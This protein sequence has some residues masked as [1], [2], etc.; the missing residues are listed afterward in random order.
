MQTKVDFKDV[1]NRLMV[2]WIVNFGCIAVFASSGWY[3]PDKLVPFVGFIMLIIV[4][5]YG[6]SNMAQRRHNCSLMNHYTIYALLT[7]ATAMLIIN[8]MHTRWYGGLHTN[9]P[10]NQ[11]GP[12]IS[13]LWVMS[14]AAV[15]FLIAIFRRTKPYYCVACKA[16]NDIS[17]RCAVQSN[18]FH[19]EMIFQ[20][21]MIFGLCLTV[22]IIGWIYY[23]YF[24]I[25][26]NINV[27][28]TF[29]YYVIPLVVYALSVVYLAAR[30]SGMRFEATI[31]PNVQ[32]RDACTT[33][34]FMIVRGDEI[35]L[36]EVAHD[37][38]SNMSM[39]DT[40]AARTLSMTEHLRMSEARSIFTELSGTDKFSLRE[41]FTTSTPNNNTLHYA[42]F[43]DDDDSGMPYLQGSWFNLYE[44]SGMMKSGLVARSFAYEMHR[45]YTMTLAWKTYDVNGKR[46][47][48]IKNYRPTFRLSDFKHWEVD[49]NDLQWLNV[50]KN[51]E[52]VPFSRLRKFWRTYITH[53][54][55][56][57]RRFR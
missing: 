17:V 31:T 23:H 27:P 54:D 9:V 19:N 53:S 8:L 16:Q 22:A 43:L 6:G 20:L 55:L 4:W 21:R 42:A 25:N 56:L 47:Y 35:M 12:F 32:E 38:G 48:P 3:V 15:Y 49:Y 29:F 10:L 40:P 1:F 45:V 30:Y 24:Y 52:D 34:R 7:C 46:L 28:D 2:G 33:V 11:E 36:R 39:W 5:M 50:A 41:L 14:I 57:W 18:V 26:I 51:N 13:S 37:S 44:V